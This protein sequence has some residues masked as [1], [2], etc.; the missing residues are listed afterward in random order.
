MSS[1]KLL[2]IIETFDRK[3][4]KEIQK[5]KAEVERQNKIIKQLKG[6]FEWTEKQKQA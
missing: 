4:T 6:L 1:F 2:E 5:L 3:H